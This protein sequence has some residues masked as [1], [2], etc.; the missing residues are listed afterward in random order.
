MSLLNKGPRDVSWDQGAP[1]FGA[2]PSHAVNKFTMWNYGAREPSHRRTLS[3]LHAIK[4]SI[5]FGDK[6]KETR[7]RNKGNALR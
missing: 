1:T 5:N 4:I 2:P 7:L 6:S 3:L